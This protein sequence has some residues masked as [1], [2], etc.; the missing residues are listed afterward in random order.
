VNAAVA[1]A[2]EVVHTTGC[3]RAALDALAYWIVV[4]RLADGVG[5]LR[6]GIAGAINTGRAATVAAVG[7]VQI[8]EETGR[9]AHGLDRDEL[10]RHETTEHAADDGERDVREAADV[11]SAGGGG[12]TP[13]RESIA[14]AE[15]VRG[16]VL[17]KASHVLTVDTVEATEE[18]R[19]VPLLDEAAVLSADVT[20]ADSLGELL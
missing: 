10:V 2:S 6:A 11:T 15:E 1:S 19:T 3:E 18:A 12:A 5:S 16:L 9:E 7:V 14:L 8:E 17:E 20:P 4:D 13:S